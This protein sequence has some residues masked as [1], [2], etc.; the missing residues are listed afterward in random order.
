MEYDH[1]ASSHD[2]APPAFGEVRILPKSI[3]VGL[4]NASLKHQLPQLIT[5]CNTLYFN[6]CG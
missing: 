3:P 4:V 2:P 5:P 6:I 1:Q